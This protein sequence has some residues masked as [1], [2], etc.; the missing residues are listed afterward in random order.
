V[1]TFGQLIGHV[2]GANYVFCAAAKG[3]KSPQ[4]EAAFES[5]ATK[6]A[7][8]KAWDESVTYCNGAFSALT[9]RSAA[10][11]IDM[12]FEQGKG[13]RV[14]ALMG[15]VGHLNEHYGNIV[16]YLRING[17]VPPTSRR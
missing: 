8:L 12:P 6:A 17:I 15:N 9:D 10:E 14:S 7:L 11:A 4:A 3:E 1:R 13:A 2:A 5:L 16:T